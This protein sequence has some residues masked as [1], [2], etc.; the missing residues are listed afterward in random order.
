MLTEIISRI[1]ND[2]TKLL[3]D[4]LSPH[5]IS[6]QFEKVAAFLSNENLHI[7][8]IDCKEYY[9]D[10][11]LSFILLM[12]NEALA[13]AQFELASKFRFLEKELQEE[14]GDN[15][16]TKLKTEPF[17]FEYRGNRIIFHFSKR[18]ENQRLIANLIERYNF[19]L[20]KPGFHKNAFLM[21][22][23]QK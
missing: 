4:D 7:E 22:A 15:E 2:L 19:I 12:K 21:T 5:S 16:Y 18:K 3:A 9:E 6:Y 10:G 11:D 8:M 20:Q 17:F 14:K 13:N 23:L 1:L